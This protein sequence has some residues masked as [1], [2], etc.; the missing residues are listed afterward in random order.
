MSKAITRDRLYKVIHII[1][2]DLKLKFGIKNPHIYVCGLNPHA[3]EDG[4][5]G[6]EEIHT[7]IPALDELR[8]AG[9]TITGPLPADTIFH[10]AARSA[11]AYRH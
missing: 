4:H 1:N 7:I 11:Y 10:F 3:G 6:T 8:E 2:T 5:I 9:I